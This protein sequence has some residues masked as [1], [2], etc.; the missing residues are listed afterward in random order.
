MV[1]GRIDA[2]ACHL[3]T[4]YGGVRYGSRLPPSS[5]EVLE[6][7]SRRGGVFLRGGH[8][9]VWD[10]LGAGAHLIRQLALQAREGLPM[11]ARALRL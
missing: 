3:I 1:Y 9:P 7:S 10:D 5:V 8:L 6:M 2:G 11:L 4:V